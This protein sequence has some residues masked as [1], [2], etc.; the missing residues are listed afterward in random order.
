MRLT[1]FSLILCFPFL[2]SAQ[3]NQTDA[4]GLRQGK[5]EKRYP[6]GKLIYEG[7]FKDGEPVGEWTR[8]Y[9]GGLVKAKIHYD[10]DSAFTQLFNEQGKKIAE[11]NYVNEKRAGKWTLYS[12]GI[13]ISEESYV[14][15]QKHGI[16]RK[17]YPTGELFEKTEWKNGLQEGDYEVFFKNGE[18][19]MQCKYSEGKRNGLC[20]SYF[21]NGRVEMEAHYKN[22]LRHGEWKFYNNEGDHLY[23]LKY[24]EGKLLNPE[25]RDSIGNQQIQEME[26]GRHNIPDPE[27]FMQD[28]SEYMMQMERFR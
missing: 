13:K 21:K 27:K 19:Y 2:V 3:I 20:L 15:G 25:V 26:K 18:P 7:Q 14:E 23:T 8:Y 22:N 1:I 24:E 4:D 28:P 17:F 12:D 5:W 9:P 11:G 10:T 16:S 6:S